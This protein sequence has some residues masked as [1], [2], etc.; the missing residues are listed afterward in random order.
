M[1]VQIL[2]S[3][4]RVSERPP[5][6]KELLS[7]LTASSLC[8]LVISHFGFKDRILVLIAPVPGQYVLVT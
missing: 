1:Y 5:F 8:N 2:L 7:W 3:S 6:G 4:V